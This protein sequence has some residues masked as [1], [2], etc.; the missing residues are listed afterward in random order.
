MAS[1]SEPRTA[2]SSPKFTAQEVLEWDDWS[3]TD[4]ID[5]E[6]QDVLVE[7][8]Y[9]DSVL[10]EDPEIG[11]TVQLAPAF[12][13]LPDEAPAAVVPE[14]TG[15]PPA[16]RRRGRPTK[17]APVVVPPPKRPSTPPPTISAQERKVSKKG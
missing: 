9:Q 11:N 16:K 6:D 14:A 15:A 13:D 17:R 3:D 2:P 4:T 10:F 1:T 8:V 5:D 12:E 7:P